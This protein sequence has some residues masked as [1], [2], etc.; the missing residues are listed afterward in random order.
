MDPCTEANTKDLNSPSRRLLGGCMPIGWNR[1]STTEYDLYG[2]WKEG[3]T[4]LTLLL[5]TTLFIDIHL[6]ELLLF[7]KLVRI[8]GK[9]KVSIRDIRQEYWD[10]IQHLPP[11]TSM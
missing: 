7:E 8:T 5:N 10:T 11:K 6:R 1:I 4:D 3:F 9:W 2:K